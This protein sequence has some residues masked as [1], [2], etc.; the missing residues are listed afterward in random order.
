MIESYSFGSIVIA[1]QRY[2][3]DLK[4]IYG[5]VV[6]DWWRREGHSICKE[7]I[8]DVMAARTEVFILGTGAYGAM[9]VPKAFKNLMDSHG[10]DLIA[11]PTDKAVK[12]YNELSTQKNVAAGLHLTC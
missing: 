11:V 5:R 10:I 8:S 4:I 6:P 3:T 2:S 1:G 12:A 9:K 7:D